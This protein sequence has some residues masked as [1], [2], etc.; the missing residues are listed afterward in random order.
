MNCTGRFLLRKWGKHVFC[1]AAG[2]IFYLA[3][4]LAAGT[5]GGLIQNE[6]GYFLARNPCGQ[7]D[8][9]YSLYVEGLKTDPVEIEIT[10]GE[11]KLN[12]EQGKQI[13][14]TAAGLL[15][16]RILGENTSLS[17]VRSDLMLPGELPEYGLTLTWESERPELLSSMGL[18]H[19]EEADVSGENVYLKARMTNGIFDETVEIPVLI[20]PKEMDSQTEFFKALAEASGEDEVGAM[21]KLPKEI[22]SHPLKYK[23]A[24]RSGNEIL[25]LLGVVAAICLF[26]KEKN[27]MEKQRKK[28]ENSLLMDYSEILSRFAVLTGAGYTI[29]QAWRKMVV[30][31]EGKP[32]RPVYEEMRVALNRM[33][34]GISELQSYGEFGRR[35]GLRCYLRFV[36]L[37]ENNL[38]TGGKNLRNL[39]EREVETAFEQRKDLA[40]RL[41]EE[42]SA[43]LLLPLFLMLGVVMV[44][45]VAPAFL[46]LG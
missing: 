16:E 38:N 3:A 41:G 31:H 20:F 35:C 6:N 27:D 10:V 40:K 46:T 2:G 18:V 19:G 39:L 28:R 30:D 15:C 24:N 42:A 45:I 9:E 34:T 36:S 7:G 43:K 22:G 5:D 32:P 8:T 11:Q 29:R 17:E 26:L 25:L 14:N 13:L 4:E 12:R 33:N 21:M 44:M 1:L 23:E 37:L